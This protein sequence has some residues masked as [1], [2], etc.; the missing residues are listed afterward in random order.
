[1][2]WSKGKIRYILPKIIL[3]LFI[4]CSGSTKP[5]AI[6][7]YMGLDGE[8]RKSSPI[9]GHWNMAF[10]NEYKLIPGTEEQGERQIKL[11]KSM[12]KGKKMQKYI[13]GR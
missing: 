9:K 8:V 5:R 6:N 12:N 4:K 11:R 13:L 3:M 2:A 1:M 10:R 7:F